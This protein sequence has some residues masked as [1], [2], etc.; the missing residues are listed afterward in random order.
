MMWLLPWL[1]T[2]AQQSLLLGTVVDGLTTAQD[3]VRD[4][5]MRP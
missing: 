4:W 5:A 3:Y 2:E 1:F